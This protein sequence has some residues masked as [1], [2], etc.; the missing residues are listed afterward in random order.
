MI[1]H[2][3]GK[4]V[5]G[6]VH[7]QTIEGFW[8]LFMS[9]RRSPGLG[10]RDRCADADGPR[11]TDV[12]FGLLPLWQSRIISAPGRTFAG[13]WWPRLARDEDAKLTLIHCENCNRVNELLTTLLG[14][15]GSPEASM[16]SVFHLKV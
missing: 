16:R 4:Y 2:A 14:K 11:G 5:V 7:T 12:S 3:A 13:R 10:A 15:G 8:S 1:D 9:P 6:A